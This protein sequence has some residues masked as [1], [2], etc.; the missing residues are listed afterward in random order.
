MSV[1]L[2]GQHKIEIS[3]I[4]ES[5]VGQMAAPGGV[6]DLQEVRSQFS[7]VSPEAEQSRFLSSSAHTQMTSS[8][9]GCAVREKRA[10]LGAD[11]TRR[12]LPPWLRRKQLGGCWGARHSMV[13][14]STG[15]K[16][17]SADW[18]DRERSV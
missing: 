3:I 15:G 4:T 12:A 11:R 16:S 7:V 6:R 5:C 18:S 2:C 9:L 17:A 13:P 8:S 10:G 14:G 1:A